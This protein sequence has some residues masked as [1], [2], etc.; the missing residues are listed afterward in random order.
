M[1]K[2]VTFDVKDFSIDENPSSHFAILDMTIVSSGMN[3]HKLPITVEAIEKSSRTL[4]GKPVLTHYIEESDSLGGHDPEQIPVGVFL[5]KDIKIETK[6]GVSWLSAKAYVWKKY[7][8]EVISVFQKNN[9]KTNISMEIEVI[10]SSIEK[11][12]Y[13]WIHDFCF[14]GVTAI[15]VQPAIIG[16]GGTVLQFS[17]LMEEA[18]R[19]FSTRY[20]D[21]DFNIPTSVK[22]NSK[23]GIEL[24][25]NN[26]KR[27][28]GVSVSMAK[29][30]IT[31]STADPEK[32]KHISKYFLRHGGDN[33]EDKESKAWIDWML[34]GGNTAKVWATGLVKE[35]KTLD[36]KQ[37]SHFAK[38]DL[39][40]K[41]AIEVDKSKEAVSNDDWG[42]V[43]KSNLRKKVL[44]ASNYKT[45]VDDVYLLVESGW[46]DAPSE[47]LK[48]PVM[49]LVGGKLV[50]N[51]KAL[52]SALGYAKK[53]NESDVVSKV[54]KIYKELGLD[55]EEK[56]KV[57]NQ[58]KT[59]FS[60]NKEEEKE[61]EVKVVEAEFPSKEEEK[62]EEKKIEASEE[63]KPTED[64]NEEAKEEEKPA[65]DENEESKMSSDA[66]ADIPALMSMLNEETEE[67]REMS[68]ELKKEEKDFSKIANGFYFML[69]KYSSTIKKMQEDK[70][71]DEEKMSELEKFKCD[72]EKK[73]FNLKVDATI[74]EIT[75]Y[76]SE[77][78]ITTWKERASQ[79]SISNIDLWEKEIKA[80]VFSIL[81]SQ[82]TIVT[83]EIK[84]IQLPF[85][86]NE[87]SKNKRKSIW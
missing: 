32:I 23:K 55:E 82:Q 1:N 80:S 44:E 66:Y 43:D 24:N 33:L 75:P 18:K 69:G 86:G 67:I 62:E 58:T 59:D 49:E 7:F 12:G 17:K 41:E 29:Y 52:A 15:G 25:K 5:D 83:D 74:S 79:F 26:N 4:F 28:S 38:D 34:W 30:I 3:L 22:N 56:L 70:K 6:S 21:L 77:S 61:E 85:G 50:Y 72:T 51:R 71:L 9:G 60:E 78:E 10:D 16:S 14:L 84:K 76:L 40:T 54:E 37:I 65:E 13:E 20:D 45:L 46:E 31:N 39:G 64:E 11:D 57:K 19:E 42:N 36:E 2:K 53:E 81:K 48:Y 35:M 87:V 47:H 63:E 73:E 8:P 68:S 27:A